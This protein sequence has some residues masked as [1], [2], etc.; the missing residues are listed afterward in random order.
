MRVDLMG[1]FSYWSLCPRGALFRVHASLLI[2]K[3][4][5]R[6]LSPDYVN[7]RLALPP[8]NYVLY[9]PEFPFMAVNAPNL[10]LSYTGI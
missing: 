4:S 2:V 3:Q 1:S 7:C 6:W 9:S 8:G 10:L 5:D